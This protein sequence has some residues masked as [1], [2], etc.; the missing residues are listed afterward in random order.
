MENNLCSGLYSKSR[1]DLLMVLT[2][3]MA[4]S[5]ESIKMLDD[6]VEQQTKK[7]R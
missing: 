6:Q 1:M 4:I 5:L 7:L 2:S 3:Q